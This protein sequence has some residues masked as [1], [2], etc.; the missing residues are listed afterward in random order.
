MAWAIGIAANDAVTT[1]TQISVLT[2]PGLF[3]LLIPEP[4]V[5]HFKSYMVIHSIRMQL[6]C[7]LFI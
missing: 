3:I 1:N 5:Q 6:G 4:K 7:D 2:F